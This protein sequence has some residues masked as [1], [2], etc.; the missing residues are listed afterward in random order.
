MHQI[1]RQSTAKKTDCAIEIPD[2]NAPLVIIL[3]GKTGNGK[4]AT[5]NLLLGRDVFLS[6]PGVGS[7]TQDCARAAGTWHGN[8]LIIVDTPGLGDP[9][10]TSQ[11][12]QSKIQAGISAAAVPGAR[13]ALLLVFGLHLRVTTED[14]ETISSL[15]IMFGKSMMHSAV[16]VWTHGSLLESKTLEEYFQGAS[17]GLSLLLSQVRGGSVVVEHKDRTQE[18]AQLFRDTI[19]ESALGVSGTLPTPRPLG[20]KKARRLRQETARRA[21]AEEARLHPEETWCVVL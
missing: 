1:A 21:L 14:V 9:N 12:I 11:S 17:P 3:L 13:Y 20:G 19:L 10:H 2:N 4:S 15:E 6:Q 5:G 18:Q 7:V 8:A 16:A